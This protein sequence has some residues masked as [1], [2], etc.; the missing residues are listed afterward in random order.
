VAWGKGNKVKF[1]LKK[2]VPDWIVPKE[3]FRDEKKCN[4][5]QV[6]DWACDRVFPEE[7]IG[8]KELLLELGLDRYEPWEIAKKTR[9]SLMEDW[10]WL[11]FRGN[12]KYEEWSA[13]GRAG[14]PP[15]STIIGKL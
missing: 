6:I 13:R 7:R 5:S 4:A 14:I 12:E 9:A 15:I 1:A 8:A 11:S 10:Y 2:G 3:L